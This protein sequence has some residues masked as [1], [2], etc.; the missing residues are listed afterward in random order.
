M[1]V[2]IVITSVW[3]KCYWMPYVI[4]FGYVENILNEINARSKCI[5][6]EFTVCFTSCK[7]KLQ[8]ACMPSIW[9]II[10]CLFLVFN[11]GNLPN[12]NG[13]CI[14]V[15]IKCVECIT[16][17]MISPFPLIQLPRLSTLLSHKMVWYFMLITAKQQQKQV[18]ICHIHFKKIPNIFHTIMNH[19]HGKCHRR[20]A[21]DR[22]EEKK[23]LHAHNLLVACFMWL[24][25]RGKAN[26]RTFTQNKHC[27]IFSKQKTSKTENG[28]VRRAIST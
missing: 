17:Q 13:F 27:E 26:R 19:P 20:N 18:Q 2:R 22:E 10:R 3:C 1:L 4:L 12:L 16:N 5:L 11:F 23:V 28:A 15:N 6:A 25:L 9:C 24:L 14:S 8:H 21:Q 7:V